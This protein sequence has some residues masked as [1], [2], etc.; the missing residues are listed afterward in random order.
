MKAH[1]EQWARF[2]VGV[3]SCILCYRLRKSGG[4]DLL[5][6]SSSAYGDHIRVRGYDL[7]RALGSASCDI[8]HATRGTI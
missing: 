5:P 8:T 4:Y 2:V 3:E 1:T 7:L 6:A